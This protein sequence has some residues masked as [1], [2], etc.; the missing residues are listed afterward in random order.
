MGLDIF[1][2]IPS[3]KTDESF[4]YLNLDEFVDNKEFLQNY[5]HL[6][7]DIEYFDRE[8]E[9]LVFPDL[10]TKT[11]V[12]KTNKSYSDIPNLVGDLTYLQ[13]HANQLA[14]DNAFPDKKP[15]I[16]K[17]VNNL[18][19]KDKSKEV[20]YHSITYKSPPKTKKVLFYSVKGYQRKG[21]NSKFIKDFVN[22]KLYFDKNSLLKAYS[23]LDPTWSDDKTELQQHFKETFIDNF[24]EGESIF[25]ISW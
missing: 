22:E 14:A 6:I 7:T 18:L 2:V 17:I 21:M 11:L 19:T 24:I 13:E 15:T 23:Y 1:H 4:D 10:A 12:S 16:L 3:I 25:F 5:Q 9:I 20:Y 8:F